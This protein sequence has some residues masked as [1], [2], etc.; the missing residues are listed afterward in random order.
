MSLFSGG[1]NPFA[2]AVNKSK[3]LIATPS[4]FEIRSKPQKITRSK[5]ADKKAA[6]PAPLVPEEP[7]SKVTRKSSKDKLESSVKPVKEAPPKK[8]EAFKPAPK[9][10]QISKKPTGI[11]GK[12][13]KKSPAKPKAKEVPKVSAKSKAIIKQKLK[14]AVVKA[15]I[16]AK[17][18]KLKAE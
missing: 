4:K 14:M 12:L 2:K 17:S 9:P 3:T 18:D 15:K 16:Q 7:L 1:K 8:A 13:S 5:S 11:R 10:A 6:K